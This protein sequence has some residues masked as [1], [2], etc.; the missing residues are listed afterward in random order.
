MHEEIIEGIDSIELVTDFGGKFISDHQVIL[1]GFEK[2]KQEMLLIEDLIIQGDGASRIAS[3]YGA[4]V[5]RQLGIFNTIR[6]VNPN[7]VSPIDFRDIKYG[8]FLT[9]S[10]SGSGT[11]L[12][13][14]LRLAYQNNLTC[15]NIVNVVDSPIT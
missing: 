15:F 9:V 6:I 4:Y 1:G 2:A 13:R 11:N 5:M 12:L 3:S 10:Q 14:S 7:T 8:G